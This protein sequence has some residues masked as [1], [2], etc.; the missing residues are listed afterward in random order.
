MMIEQV[1]KRRFRQLSNVRGIIDDNVKPVRSSFTC[2]FRQKCFVCLI[3]LEDLNT[4]SGLEAL[5]QLSINANDG[6]TREIVTP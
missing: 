2:H 1:P 6:S 3:A 4:R 5:G